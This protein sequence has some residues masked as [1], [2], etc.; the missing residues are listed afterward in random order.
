LNDL[1]ADLKTY[2]LKN[3]RVLDVKT[4][5]GS[6]FDADNLFQFVLIPDETS[7]MLNGLNRPRLFD[8]L[9]TELNPEYRWGY[10]EAGNR[11]IQL[12]A[13]AE[14]P[15]KRLEDFT[16]R[17]FYTDSTAL[18]ISTVTHL[19]KEPVQTVIRRENQQYTRFVSFEYRG[20]HGFAR[21]FA[22]EVIETFPLPPGAKL[23]FPKLLFFMQEETKNNAAFL[24]LLCLSCVSL[25]IAATLESVRNTFW[26]LLAIPL[27]AVGVMAGALYLDIYFGRGAIAGTLLLMGII[28]NNS[29]LLVYRYQQSLDKGVSGVRAWY[30]TLRERARAILITSITTLAGLAPILWLSTEEF[31]LQ[32]STIV[33]CGLSAGTALLFVFLPALKRNPSRD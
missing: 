30:S 28:V 31:W 7:L 8:R 22:E 18:A 23:Q 2:L 33:F 21:Q 11:K 3:P 4:N 32:L 20:A 16:K 9:Q 5:R 15:S 6:W 10:V 26:V 24:V 27:G 12:I 13:R 25:T 29:I 14:R 1:S 17:T 19:T